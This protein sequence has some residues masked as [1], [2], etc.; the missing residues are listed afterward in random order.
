[1][2]TQ[3]NCK[4]AGNINYRSSDQWQG[5]RGYRRIE[6]EITVVDKTRPAPNFGA[7]ISGGG[8]FGES[9]SG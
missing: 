6:V 3:N 8:K 2:V 7:G 5:F 9:L 4:G 1:M